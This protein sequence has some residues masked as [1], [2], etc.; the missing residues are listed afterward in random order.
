MLEVSHLY[1][2]YGLSQVLFDLSLEVGE[3]ECVCLLGRN[4]AGKSTTLKTIMGL[5][6][7]QGIVRFKGQD[8]AGTVPYRIA[9]MGI[10]YVPEDRRVFGSLTVRENLEAA[11]ELNPQSRGGGVKWTVERVYDLFPRLKEREKNRATNLSGGEQQML[12]IGRTL[13]TNPQLLLLDEPSEGLAPVI[14]EMLAE[15]IGELKRTGLS[16]L[17]SEQNLHFV[18]DLGDRVYVIEKGEIAFTGSM[19]ELLANRDVQ[20]TYLAV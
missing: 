10:G 1:A 5:V 7:P 11:S 8:I 9:R 19:A 14:V 2:A 16:I 6:P 13:M 17:L 4:G 3:G 15:R 20:K 18:T 12:A